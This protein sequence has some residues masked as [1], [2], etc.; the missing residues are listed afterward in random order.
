MRP[1]LASR[2]LQEH[3]PKDVPEACVYHLNSLS[4]DHILRSLTFGLITLVPDP[5]GASEASEVLLLLGISR[6]RMGDIPGWG[7]VLQ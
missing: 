3:P 6:P 4:S 1:V 7:R 2:A 5:G